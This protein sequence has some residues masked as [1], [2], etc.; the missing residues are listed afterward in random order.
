MIWTHLPL[1]KMAT[2]SQ[3]AVLNAFS[4]MENVWIKSVHW[5]IY[6]ALRLCVGV[7]VGG[8]GVWLGCVCVGWG[9]G[10]WGW[11]D[12]WGWVVGWMGVGVGVGGGSLYS[13]LS[14][15]F[16]ISV[17]VVCKKKNSGIQEVH[18]YQSIV[19]SAL[20]PQHRYIKCSKAWDTIIN[21][22]YQKQLAIS[23]DQSDTKC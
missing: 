3:L 9:W 2:I 11:W 17:Y 12:G 21:I 18:S 5:Q 6:A 7:W 10:G 1:H 8:V 22:L 4:W 19:M 13:L 23:K 14:L 20:P 16:F 15:S